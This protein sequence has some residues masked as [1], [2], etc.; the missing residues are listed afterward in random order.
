IAFTIPAVPEEKTV[1]NLWIRASADGREKTLLQWDLGSCVFTLDKTQY[2]AG[3][4]E[5]FIV[6]W[7]K[8]DGDIET[9]ILID[10]SSIEVFLFQGKYTVTSRI[11][12]QPSSIYYDIFTEE[13]GLSVPAVRIV[14]LG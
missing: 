5:K 13:G 14:A 10:R 2:G 11:Y 9:Q 1:L 8:E 6:P 3:R 7:E 12:P 4:S